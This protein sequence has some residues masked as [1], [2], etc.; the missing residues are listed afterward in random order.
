MNHKINTKS[1]QRGACIGLFLLTAL[2]VSAVPVTFQANMSYQTEL[3]NFTPGT[4]TV[5]ARGSFNGWGSLVLTNIPGTTNYQNTF[6]VAGPVGSNFVHKFVNTRAGA[7]NGGFETGGDRRFVLSASAQTISRYFNDEW[8]GGSYTVAMTFQV[9]MGPKVFASQFN[10]AADTVEIKGGF[11]GWGGG[12]ATTNDTAAANTNLYSNTVEWTEARAPG[13]PIEYKFHIYGSQDTWE[14][15]PN[16]AWP[17][18]Q[19]PQTIPED[20]FNRV[21]SVPIKAKVYFQVDMSAQLL[22]NFDTNTEAAYVRGS[23]VGWGAPPDGLELFQDAGRPRIWTNT[24]VKTNYLVGE[25]FAYKYV[26]YNP[27]STGTKWEDGADK[28][29]SLNGTEPLD[30]GGF[31]VKTLGPTFWNNIFLSDLLPADTQVIFRVSLTNAVGV[32]GAPV[33]DGS[34]Q[35]FVNGSFVPWWGWGL[36]GNP[37]YLMSSNG[38]GSAI[39]Y[40][41]N[42]FL[43]GQPLRLTYKYSM[44]GLDNE[45]PSGQD[46]V[47]FIRATNTY[48]MPLDVFG[49][50]LVEPAVG[51]LSISAAG[52]NVILSWNGRPGVHLQSNTNLTGGTWVD[53][54]STDGASTKLVPVSS[55]NR[56]FRLLKP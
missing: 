38:I 32:G 23:A 7:P 26:I 36:G 37:T 39:Y 25:V 56:Y 15:D 52:G 48:V 27:T 33:Y 1:T 14:G 17:I 12:V 28:Q 35:V 29:V 21:C 8:A 34:Q 9:N 13:A 53:D 51:S 10:P 31:R 2:S 49:Q 55:G 41:T 30:V 45:A 47:R 3:G 40:Y 16:R 5:E 22:A 11:N 54:L 42:Q 43:K 20:C 50:Q 6:D 19:S 18:S 46:H 44:D 24:W 4:D